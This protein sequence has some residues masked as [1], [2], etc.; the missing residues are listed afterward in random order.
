MVFPGKKLMHKLCIILTVVPMY[1]DF[2]LVIQEMFLGN[3]VG[4]FEN[5]PHSM[6]YEIHFHFRNF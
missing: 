4:E 1:M 5:T 3:I 2:S 6:K